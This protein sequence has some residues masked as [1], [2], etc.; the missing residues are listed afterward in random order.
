M[1]AI[2]C[3]KAPILAVCAVNRS[4]VVDPNSGSSLSTLWF[5]FVSMSSIWPPK[6]WFLSVEVAVYHPWYALPMTSEASG[7]EWVLDRDP[8]KRLDTRRTVTNHLVRVC[9]LVRGEAEGWFR[10]SPKTVRFVYCEIWTHASDFRG[11]PSAGWD[12]WVWIQ[13]PASLATDLK[14]ERQKLR[15][16]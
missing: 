4:L 7:H 13:R 8:F 5:Q 6:T 14:L 16:K 15:L 1:T 9:S 12:T 10:E 2:V 11:N 3:L